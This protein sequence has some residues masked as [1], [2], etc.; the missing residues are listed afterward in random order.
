VSLIEEARSDERPLWFTGSGTTPVPDGHT[1]VSTKA[2]GGIVDY[3]PDD[4]TVVVRGGTTLAELEE[5]LRERGHTAVLPE[6]SP[7]R[8]V[9]GVIA[10]GASGYRRYRYG[11]TRDRVIGVT[12]VTGYGEVVHAG[13]QLV[14]NVTGYDIPRLVTGSNGALGFIA[15]I[16]LKLWPDSSAP[17]TIR[18]KDPALEGSSRYQPV[19]VLETE[20]GGSVYVANAEDPA[21][22]ESAI[23]GYRWPSPLEESVVLA[24]NVPARFVPGAVGRVRDLGAA[25]FVA[26]HGVGV[27]DVGWGTVDEL[28]V[29]DLRTWAES[30]G[31]SLAVSKRG[32]LLSASFSR[33]GEIPS[34]AAI[35]LRLKE[36]FDPDR[37]CNP[38]VLPGGV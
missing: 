2:L 17:R 26:Q 27:V 25:R 33:W 38:G 29:V 37:V 22:Q 19:A 31:G 9:G 36:L 7:E 35:Q 23:E 30:I 10:S 21:R 12:I 18:S 1:V 13:G 14:K 11:P 34:T 5:V 16:A 3:R 32:P 4:L 20:S 24:V 8:T 6:T 15:E 28:E